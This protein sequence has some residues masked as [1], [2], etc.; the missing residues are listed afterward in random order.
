MIGGQSTNHIDP[1]P[2]SGIVAVPARQDYD[3]QNSDRK[4]TPHHQTHRDSISRP[5]HPSLPFPSP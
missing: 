1:G 5:P 3:S 4:Q 2:A